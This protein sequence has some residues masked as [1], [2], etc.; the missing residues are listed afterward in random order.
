M[1]LAAIPIFYQLL[2]A[3]HPAPSYSAPVSIVVSPTPTPAKVLGATTIATPTPIAPQNIGGE[4]RVITI[5]VL[6]DSMIETLGKD[7]PAL[8]NSLRQYFPYD[9][10]NLINYG[11]GSQNINY[12]LSQELPAMI[13]QNPDIVVI[14][15]FAYNNFGNT[16]DGINRHWLTLGAISTSIKQKLPKAKIIIAATIAPNSVLFENGVKNV[17]L[18]SLEKLERTSTIKLYL[19]NAVNFANSQGFPLA[20]AYH[21]S[22]FNNNGLKEFINPT[23]NLHPSTAGATLFSDIVADTIFRNKLLD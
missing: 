9:I 17:Y 10:F 23:D 13:P 1:F 11:T 14:E 22:L 21:L 8:K 4:G 20:D 3:Y 15:S 16:E 2:E 6:G 18:T 19:Q 12:G 5:A 7:L